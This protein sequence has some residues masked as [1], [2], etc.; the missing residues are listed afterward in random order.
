MQMEM[1]KA[2][3][4]IDQRKYQKFGRNHKALQNPQITAFK[5]KWIH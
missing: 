3:A 4:S 2:L 5:N 1:T